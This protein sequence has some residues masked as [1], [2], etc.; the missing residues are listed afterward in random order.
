MAQLIR[1]PTGELLEFDDDESQ[2]Y[3]DEVIERDF[4]SPAA[5]QNSLFGRL[6]QA[7]SGGNPLAQGPSLSNGERAQGLM[8][9]R[10]STGKDPGFGVTPL[11]DDS[12]AENVRFGVDYFHALLNKYGNTRHAL[13]A[14]NW[15]PSK[16]DNWIARGE[17]TDSIPAETKGFLG[18]TLPPPQEPLPPGIKDEEQRGFFSSLGHSF[19]G[20]AVGDNPTMFGHAMMGIGDLADSDWFKEKGDALAKMGA[21]FGKPF[22]DQSGD[23]TSLVD[24]VD[25]GAAEVLNYIGEGTGRA[26]GTTLGPM[27]GGLLG[28]AGGGALG[29]P[30]G[31]TF[32][33]LV[34][35][36]GPSYMLNYGE[37][38]ASLMQSELLKER[39]ASNDLTEKELAR[40]GALAAIPMALLDAAG[41]L[42]LASPLTH[43]AK[44]QVGQSIVNW[45]GKN[46]VQGMGVEGITEGLQQAINEGTL[47]STEGE[48]FL[49]KQN[50]ISIVDA[51]I[52]GALGG[53]VLAAGAATIGS[54]EEAQE[55]LKPK[56]GEK[57]PTP[58][59]G[60]EVQDGLK[61]VSGVVQDDGSP[62]IGLSDGTIVDAQKVAQ[63]ALEDRISTPPELTES[64]ETSSREP[65]IPDNLR[66]PLDDA[67]GQP[68]KKSA[69]THPDLVWQ[70]IQGGDPSQ[71]PHEV[72]I[73]QALTALGSPMS[74]QRLPDLI[75]ELERARN[76]A[77]INEK[78]LSQE[79]YF[80][81]ERLSGRAPQYIISEDSIPGFYDQVQRDLERNPMKT[82]TLGKWAKIMKESGGKDWWNLLG[83]DIIFD[84]WSAS[85]E[86]VVAQEPINEAVK[87]RDYALAGKLYD[88]TRISL[89]VSKETILKYLRQ[90]QVRV[91]EHVTQTTKE[92]D[93]LNQELKEL[94]RQF[95]GA[96]TADEEAIQ[97][98][99]NDKLAEIQEVSPH[100]LG[101]EKTLSGGENYRELHIQAND[102]DIVERWQDGHSGLEHIENPVVRLRFNEHRT[103]DGKSVFMIEEVQPPTKT[104]FAK[105]PAYFQNNWQ[106]IAF[107]RAIIWAAQNGFDYVGWTT[108]EQQAKRWGHQIEMAAI[109]KIEDEWY[110]ETP[111]HGSRELTLAQVPEEAIDAIGHQVEGHFKF[112]TPVAISTT[113]WERDLYDKHLVGIAKKLGKK[114]GSKPEIIE[115]DA[116]LETWEEHLKRT[117]VE[118]PSGPKTVYEKVHG[119]ALP[120]SFQQDVKGYGL[121][122]I[123]SPEA[124]A[125]QKGI[126]GKVW[127]ELQRLHAKVAPSAHLRPLLKSGREIPEGSTVGG[128]QA[129]SMIYVALGAEDTTSNYLHEAFHY[130]DRL[131]MLDDAKP[132]LEAEQPR[133]QE[134]V[135]RYLTDMGAN[136][137]QI[138]NTLNLMRRDPAEALAYPAGFYM[139]MREQGLPV[140][141]FPAP[142]RPLL[143]AIFKFFRR[144]RNY[145]NGLG[146]QTAEDVFD[147]IRSG[148]MAAKLAKAKFSKDEP[149]TSRFA[150]E[151]GNRLQI[152]SQN[153]KDWYAGSVVTDEMGNPKPLMR[154]NVLETALE[155]GPI[156]EAMYFYDDPKA[157][158]DHALETQ[159]VLDFL[160]QDLMSYSSTLDR[161]LENPEDMGQFL[162][163]LMPG[164]APRVSPSFVVIKDPRYALDPINA[165]ERKWLMETLKNYL[166][167]VPEDAAEDNL[168]FLQSAATL[169]DLIN[170]GNGII[171]DLALALTNKLGHDGLRFQD[172]RGNDVWAFTGKAQNQRNLIDTWHEP[173][174]SLVPTFKKW[175]RGD[176]SLRF[177]KTGDLSRVLRAILAPSD[178]AKLWAEGAVVYNVA[179]KMKHFTSTMTADAA[180]L[181]GP[182]MRR[183]P[184][185]RRLIDSAMEQARLQGRK[186]T[187]D[188]KGEIVIVNNIRDGNLSK[189]GDK[190]TIQGDDVPALMSMQ[191]AGEHIWDGLTEAFMFDQPGLFLNV[192]DLAA[193][194]WS[195]ELAK[196]SP[197]DIASIAQALRTASKEMDQDFQKLAE[198]EALRLDRIVTTLQEMRKLRDEVTYI[199]FSRKGT[200]GMIVED[201]EGNQLEFETFEGLPFNR[202]KPNMAKIEE[203]KKELLDRHPGSRIKIDETTGTEVFKMTHDNIRRMAGDPI[204]SMDFLV[205]QLSK[206][207]QKTYEEIRPLIET[208]VKERGFA[209]HMKKA[210]MLSGY[211]TNFEHSWAKYFVGAAGFAGRQKYGGAL[212]KAVGAIPATKSE[213]IA[214]ARSYA[215]YIMSPVQELS[216]LRGLMFTWFLGGNLSSALIQL[217]ALPMYAA[218][219]LGQFTSMANAHL[220]VAKASKDAAKILRKMA[221]MGEEFKEPGAVAFDPH[222][223][224]EAFKHL[225]PHE[226]EAIKRAWDEG[227]I[228]PALMIQ[229]MGM[230]PQ[231]T[232]GIPFGV[233]KGYQDAII[234]LSKPFGLMEKTA[235]IAQFL[236]VYRA[237]QDPKVLENANR[238]LGA[239]HQWQLETE[240]VP[241]AYDLA[242]YQVNT[243]MGEFDKTNRTEYERFGKGAGLLAF[244]FQSWV[245]QILSTL[246]FSAS[247]RGP[248][249]KRAFAMSAAWLLMFAGI[250]GLPGAEDLRD[251]IEW[252]WKNGTGSDLDL[253]RE[254]KE[255]LIME[256]ELEPFLAEAIMNGGMQ[257]SGISIGPRTGLGKLPGS[258]I[259]SA[260]FG[261]EGPQAFLGPLGSTVLG[262]AEAMAARAEAGEGPERYREF[263]PSFMKNLI[264]A[265]I[266]WQTDGYRSRKGQVLL[267]PDKIGF[268]QSL[269]KAVGFM[270]ARMARIQELRRAQLRERGDQ[271]LKPRYRGKLI[272][273][274][275][276]AIQA[277]LRGDKEG[278][279]EALKEYR[280]LWAEIRE[281]NQGKATEDLIIIDPK[282]ISRAAILNM[283]PH[284]RA[285]L[286]VQKTKVKALRDLEKV[287]P[288]GVVK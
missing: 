262:G 23:F 66:P 223:M 152:T 83:D 208:L 111:D 98:Q 69:Q 46:Y 94:A 206:N 22:E 79:L 26:I 200:W 35:A 11:Q 74:R 175:K 187:V 276:R 184:E 176:T 95:E 120:I 36:T 49:T 71:F 170:I 156:G 53:G 38:R 266:L 245:R 202:N 213:L 151:A 12:P 10:P 51:T 80:V 6:I 180:A 126:E 28:F 124:K 259:M 45:V 222:T 282:S 280:S 234:W 248:E 159:A 101:E 258:N 179:Q 174:F 214:Q 224:E 191:K 284:L 58:L 149:W 281:R 240:G 218:P 30:V 88:S 136:G 87:S 133:L 146:F 34:G 147:P 27:L 96:R 283:H 75:V 189:F 160:K 16:V 273:A 219:Q 227:I 93:K 171:P 135:R 107:R 256:A 228:A 82:A 279:K 119:L 47:A 21:K 237:A 164:E 5:T 9:I 62:G 125:K 42:K 166:A 254:F 286:G 235:R 1:L 110:A 70:A 268:G 15:G 52:K 238:V 269:S 188:Y 231:Q 267:G 178:I 31:A 185:N 116:D 8:Q 197:E 89:K 169:Q 50:L 263:L 76:W 39:L 232:S 181:A 253:N 81:A 183:P 140:T 158:G 103:P 20:A 128:M 201:V 255:L 250:W 41:A 211:D 2:D 148:E 198:D 220:Q 78:P 165:E 155:P 203:R 205:G 123:Y 209:S 157:A 127:E 90:N 186:L 59:D 212:N 225:K 84:A 48:D 54:K 244:Q 77:A 246:A 236:A 252:A 226:V 91:S 216:F 150:E 285:I 221:V 230:T 143:E 92:R 287:F 264:D 25:D 44:R 260:I 162:E 40:I 65:N 288:G 261:D 243:V 247:R 130:F 57:F 278:A 217:T 60:Q 105:M 131:G 102:Q 32:G 104:N 18:K 29:G 86:R 121:K 7:E 196:S 193:V 272:M 177:E 113:T 215:D 68:V 134:I 167:G 153:F 132:M 4:Y 14:W 161:L 172:Q 122:F 229:Q 190:I 239:E 3:I 100:P 204:L 137:E 195:E 233:I 154:A 72:A 109:Q 112:S 56:P 24:G 241:T 142:V 199:P 43:G 13:M 251:I 275:T 17:P 145:M 168:A 277:N 73:A 192:P 61:V 210:S 207:S 55:A 117:A 118:G 265:T 67:A 138:E 37:M 99:Y 182:Y 141:N 63:V 139:G 270:P 173:H 257:W 64:I 194:P 144:L 129:G 85:P 106:A 19:A 271:G 249:G 274:L 114:F 115:I 33:A 108:G 242:R 97:V 163:H